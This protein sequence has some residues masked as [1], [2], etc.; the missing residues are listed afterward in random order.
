MLSGKVK[1]FNY[2]KGYGF[3]T[4]EEGDKDVFVH[5]TAMR[6]AQLKR[7]DEGQDIAYELKEENGKICATNLT[8]K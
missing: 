3:I 8:L 5:I 4:P 1:W 7:L 2:K 6:E